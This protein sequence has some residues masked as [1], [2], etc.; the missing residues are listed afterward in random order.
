MFS[1]LQQKRLLKRENEEKNTALSTLL[2]K[3]KKQTRESLFSQFYARRE[4]VSDQ[5]LSY[6]ILL[7]DSVST[8]PKLN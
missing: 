3:K 1:L 2:H 5:G 6:L 8:I 7:T 4:P